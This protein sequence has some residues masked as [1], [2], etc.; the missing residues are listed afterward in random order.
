MVWRECEDFSIEEKR[1][2]TEKFRKR[3]LTLLVDIPCGLQL[4][5][6]LTGTKSAFS[7]EEQEKLYKDRN[8]PQT[9]Y[10]LSCALRKLEDNSLIH[11]EGICYSL[12]PKLQSKKQCATTP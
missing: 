6:I 11:F 8:Y 9:R 4:D 2:Y 10:F 12:G 5:D 3:A 1:R 7:Q